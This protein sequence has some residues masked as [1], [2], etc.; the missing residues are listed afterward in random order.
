MS[1]Q[2]LE[3]LCSVE[4]LLIFKFQ[5]II[6]YLKLRLKLLSLSTYLNI[7][8]L[9]YFQKCI[10]WC[11]F[12]GP[13]QRAFNLEHRK[14]GKINGSWSSLFLKNVT[15]QW[16]TT[17]PLRVLWIFAITRFNVINLI[18]WWLFSVIYSNR[19]VRDD[20]WQAR[21][22]DCLIGILWSFKG[23]SMSLSSLFESFKS[24]IWF[25]N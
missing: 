21:F 10:G 1:L 11:S 19:I 22:I 24:L 8:K 3:P 7:Y 13:R 14:E 15:I 5:L 25:L 20:G 6:E 2:G 18:S 17:T 16:C 12:L 23:S 4:I 9:P